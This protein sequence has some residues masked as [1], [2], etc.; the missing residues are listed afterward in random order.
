[1]AAI[2]AVGVVKDQLTQKILLHI[3]LSRSIDRRPERLCT[4]AYDVSEGDFPWKATSGEEIEAVD[5]DLAA[6]VLA[7]IK[8]PGGS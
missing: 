2:R 3:L 4:D 1:M 5:A 6:G 7:A 8:L